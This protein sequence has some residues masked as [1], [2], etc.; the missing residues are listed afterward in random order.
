MPDG[1]GRP[2]VAVSIFSLPSCHGLNARENLSSELCPPL[3]IIQ[4][5]YAAERAEIE[6]H[7]IHALR[8]EDDFLARSVSYPDFVEHVRVLAGQVADN[9]L[10]R[11]NE[12]EDV[13]QNVR[14]QP[15]IVS[16]LTLK[17]F[18]LKGGLTV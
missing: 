12:F 5:C 11:A 7:V 2:A 15:E 1:E 17:T 3:P 16:P 6:W 8:D 10:S 13:V 18:R 4:V 14:M 9:H